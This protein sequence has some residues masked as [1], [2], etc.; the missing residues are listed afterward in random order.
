MPLLSWRS[1]AICPQLIDS[2][3]LVLTTDELEVF[4]PAVLRGL[5][6]FDTDTHPT[7]QQ[8]NA[9]YKVRASSTGAV[10]SSR[11]YCHVQG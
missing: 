3:A 10:M 4:T 6:K 11:H 5:E 9:Y 8:L 2:G 7:L 1:A